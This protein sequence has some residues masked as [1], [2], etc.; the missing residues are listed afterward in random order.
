MNKYLVLILIGGIFFFSLYLIIEY[1]ATN[2]NLFW[3]KWSRKT[4]W[5]WLPFYAFQR[6][7]KEVIF[8]K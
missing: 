2:A 7:I 5:I 4:L 8:K 1:I 3:N 6:L